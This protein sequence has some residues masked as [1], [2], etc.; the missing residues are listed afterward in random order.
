VTIEVRAEDGSWIPHGMGVLVIEEGQIA[1]IDAFL[2]PTL[3][4]RSG[5]PAGR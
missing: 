4:A 5:V 1:A 3:L 2:D